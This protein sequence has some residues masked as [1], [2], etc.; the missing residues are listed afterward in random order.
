MATSPLSKPHLQPRG[1]PWL[2]A[3]QASSVAPD[4]GLSA[5][6]LQ[7][8]F[9]RISGDA[10]ARGRSDELGALALQSGAASR[11]RVIELAAALVA[12]LRHSQREVTQNT[13]G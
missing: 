2:S 7:D 1:S 5:T 9:E 3:P 6:A 10:R 11:P 13:K 8:R 12:Q 4:R